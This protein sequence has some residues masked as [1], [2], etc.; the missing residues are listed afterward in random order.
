[1]KTKWE[2]WEA[3]LGQV[4]AE[5]EAKRDWAEESDMRLL[6]NLYIQFEPRERFFVRVTDWEGFDVVDHKI[7]GRF[8]EVIEYLSDVDC[9]KYVDER[10]EEF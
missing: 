2:N 3:T 6:F 4:T 1:M 8:D 9:E 7:F 10:R 5:Y